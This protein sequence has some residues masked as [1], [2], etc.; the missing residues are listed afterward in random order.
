MNTRCKPGDLAYIVRD[1]WN[2]CDIGKVVKV[3]KLVPAYEWAQE[4]DPEWRC[5]AR[6]PLQGYDDDGNSFP[7]CE[8]DIPDAWLRPIT[9]LPIDEETNEDVKE[10]A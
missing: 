4:D 8:S 5:V 9:G 1:D 3:V 2:P 10:P 6:E 7:S